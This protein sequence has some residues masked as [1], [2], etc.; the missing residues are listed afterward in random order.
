MPPPEGAQAV[1][2]NA[3]P[4]LVSIRVEAAVRHSGRHRIR[5]GERRHCVV[6]EEAT[7]PKEGKVF[8]LDVVVLVDRTHD[9]AD[10]RSVDCLM[11]SS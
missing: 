6:G 5:E 4:V 3:P 11:R 10:D 9:V 7:V 8:R 1:G 2:E